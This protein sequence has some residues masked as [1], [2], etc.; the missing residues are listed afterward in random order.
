MSDKRISNTNE[1]NDILDFEFLKREVGK[2]FPFYD[3]RYDDK[4]A[5]FFCRIDKD[6]LE[7]KFDLLRYSLKKKNYVPILRYEKG[8]DVIYVVKKPYR[9]EK[10]I[11]I[12]IFLIISTIITTI[13]IINNNIIETPNK[14]WLYVPNCSAQY[15]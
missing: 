3:F 7:E 1:N 10:S 8:E 6:T 15:W 9:K 5:I 2:Q 4:N 12:N 14:I 11:W 13:I